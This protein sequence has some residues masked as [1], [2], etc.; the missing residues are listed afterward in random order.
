MVVKFLCFFQ[1]IIECIKVDDVMIGGNKFVEFYEEEF[2]DVFIS[3]V[4][5]VFQNRLVWVDMDKKKY[6]KY[7]KVY[8]VKFVEKFIEIKLDYVVIFKKKVILVVKRI[9][10]N[11]DEWDFYRGEIDFEG[12]NGM[13][14]ILGY[15]ED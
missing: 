12:V 10:D 9:F 6:Q 7:I 11:F 2:V 14:C 8:V 13:F 4:D 15:R 1:Y 5:I 3:G